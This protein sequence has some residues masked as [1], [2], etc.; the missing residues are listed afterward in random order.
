MTTSA[1]GVR[2]TGIGQ[3]AVNARDLDRAT[4][5]YRDVLELPL[6]FTIPS[7]AFFRC[8]GVRLMLG[9]AEK[10]ELDHTASILYYRVEDLRGTYEALRSR[11]VRFEDEPHLVARMP[12]HELWMTFFRDSEDNL[13]ALMAEEPLP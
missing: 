7:A 1:Q 6:L 8:G 5:F 2:L 4:A 3:V 10:P 13:L 9:T 11:G 12:D